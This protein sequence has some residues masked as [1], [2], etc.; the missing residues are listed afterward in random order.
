MA[1]TETGGG[2]GAAEKGWEERRQ[3]ERDQGASRS[4]PESRGHLQ[5]DEKKTLDRFSMGFSSTFSL[6]L[7]M[8]DQRRVSGHDGGERGEGRQR[9]GDGG[10][11]GRR[12]WRLKRRETKDTR[13][14]AGGEERLRL[15]G[16]R[17]NRNKEQRRWVMC[18]RG[19]AEKDEND[20]S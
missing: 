14:E 3:R 20:G 17:P 9:E 8:A 16:M 13:K 10:G 18:G 6:S 7:L 5:F 11:D 2:E 12:G 4:L 15:K 1:G 19:E